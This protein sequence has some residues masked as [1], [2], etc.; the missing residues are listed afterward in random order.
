MSG[1]PGFPGSGCDFG[2]CNPIGSGGLGFENADALIWSVPFCAVQPEVCVVVGL[3]VVTVG[4]VGYE[5]YELY[6]H[7]SNN[8]AQNRQFD[9]AVRQIESRCGRKLSKGDRR[10]LHDEITGQGFPIP[11]IVNIGV[12]LFCPGN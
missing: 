1:I 2:Y 5:G 11:D 7:L 6:K 3:G 12:G 4:V 10:R 8:I 9:E